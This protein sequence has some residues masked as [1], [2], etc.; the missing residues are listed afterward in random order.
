[1]WW[2]RSEEEREEEVEEVVVEEKDL[3]M[4]CV[5]GRLAKFQELYVVRYK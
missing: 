1:M 2:K 5:V 3:K 4:S